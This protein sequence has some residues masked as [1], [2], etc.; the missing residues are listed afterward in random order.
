MYDKL[1]FG[2]SLQN[3]IY[4]NTETII[5]FFSLLRSKTQLDKSITIISDNARNQHCNW[6]I[7]HDK[8]LNIKMLFL[9]S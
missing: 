3:T 4:I 5:E 1:G 8:S 9:P 6:V 2:S 7:E